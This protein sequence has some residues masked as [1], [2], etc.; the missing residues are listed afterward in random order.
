MSV[1]SKRELS[2]LIPHTGSMCLL[3]SVERWDALSIRCLARSHLDRANPLRSHGRLDVIAGLEYAAQTMAVHVGL[4]RSDASL[5]P[6]VG[7]LGA[8]R[9]LELS[10]QRIDDLAGALQID[11]RQLFAD[12]ARFVYAFSLSSSGEDLVRG[13]ASIFLEYGNVNP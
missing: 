2:R 4:L 12:G 9:E 3:E 10:A 11:A 5:R 13:R 6:A 7:Y 1:L 8:V